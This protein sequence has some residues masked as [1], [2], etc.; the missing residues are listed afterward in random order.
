M[1]HKG[2]TSEARL[3]WGKNAAK[4]NTTSTHYHKRKLMNCFQSIQNLQKNDRFLDSKTLNAFH[5]SHSPDS[6]AQAQP[7]VL[8]SRLP[9]V[10]KP[11]VRQLLARALGY[12]GAI[13]QTETWMHCLLSESLDC[14]K[15]HCHCGHS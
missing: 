2:H 7:D 3:A 4:K 12:R 11:V 10:S 14:S 1:P 6:Y 15:T 5:C 8:S 13:A 9:M